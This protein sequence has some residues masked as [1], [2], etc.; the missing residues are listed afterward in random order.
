VRGLSFSVLERWKLRDATHNDQRFMDKAARKVNQR[1]LDFSNKE[2][3]R[4]PKI[5]T[6]SQPSAKS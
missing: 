4:I 2:L 1:L 6:E 5:P 3:R